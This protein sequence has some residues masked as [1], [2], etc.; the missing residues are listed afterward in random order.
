MNDQTL[1]VVRNHEGQYSIWDSE[2]SVPAGWHVRTPAQSKDDCLEYILQ[3][4]VDM[5]P[6]SLKRESQVK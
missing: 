5:T 4:W 1:V 2:R 6:L 3:H